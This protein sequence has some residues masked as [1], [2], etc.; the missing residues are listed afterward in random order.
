MT[1]AVLYPPEHPIYLIKTDLFLL[2]DFLIS[3][4]YNLCLE[5]KF[6][7]IKCCFKTSALCIAL[8]ARL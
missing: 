2:I 8:H 6:T 4:G 1:I 5:N 3:K 7:Q